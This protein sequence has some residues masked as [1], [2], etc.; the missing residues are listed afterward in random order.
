MN[1]PPKK[2]PGAGE[3]TG[4]FKLIVPAG[5]QPRGPIQA[6]IWAR[7]C[8]EAQR[9]Y[10]EY[11]RTANQRHLSAL[12]THLHGMRLHDGRRK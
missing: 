4:R 5:Y 1:S 9:I 12:A 8:R 10:Q 7:W 6:T 3:L 11:W 2:A